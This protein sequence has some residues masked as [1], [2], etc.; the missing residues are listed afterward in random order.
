MPDIVRNLIYL[1]TKNSFTGSLLRWALIISLIHIGLLYSSKKSNHRHRASGASNRRHVIHILAPLLLISSY[2]GVLAYSTYHG[3]RP[4]YFFILLG[5]AYAVMTLMSL[6]TN[7][8]FMKKF[9]LAFTVIVA[10]TEPIATLGINNFYPRVDYTESSIYITGHLFEYFEEISKTGLYYLIPPEGLTG[11]F[12]SLVTGPNITTYFLLKFFEAV[13][14]SLCLVLALFKLSKSMLLAFLAFLLM[15][16]DPGNSFMMGRLTAS[17]YFFIYLLTVSIYLMRGDRASLLLSVIPMLPMIFDHGSTVVTSLLL[18]VALMIY[19]RMIKGYGR[20]K[21]IAWERLT[22]PALIL[23]SSTLTYWISTY[24]FYTVTSLGV[25]FANSLLSYFAIGGGQTT[26]EYTFWGY[27]TRYVKEEYRVFSYAWAYTPAVST[28]I[29]LFFLVKLLSRSKLDNATQNV[30]MYVHGV[31]GSLIA[32][33]SF[34]AYQMSEAGQYWITVGYYFTSIA[35]GLATYNIISRS[36]KVFALVAL[37]LSTVFIVLGAYSPAHAPLEH[38]DFEAAAYIFRYP[39]YVEANL[40][41]KVMGGYFNVYSDYDLPLSGGLYKPIREKIYAIL[42]GLNPRA[43]VGNHALI[44]IK[45]QRDLSKIDMRIYDVL[46]Y[47]NNYIG[48]SVD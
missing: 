35:A 45:T 5:L 20:G 14:L 18:F 43:V 39:H 48:V 16:V 37:I 30:L 19:D 24:I 11:I 36:R 2:L 6:T 38:P 42:E 10:V 4:I 25:K 33:M 46:Y 21:D 28:A 15:W 23:L 29:L 13:A 47:S 17:P 26:L 9:L 12:L 7:E 1:L 31:L 32:L 44:F 8:Q 22:M 34:T 41:G 27:S 40:I 3:F